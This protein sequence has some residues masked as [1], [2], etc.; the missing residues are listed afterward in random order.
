M[1]INLKYSDN[2]DRDYKKLSKGRK[3]YI[4]KMAGKQKLTISNYLNLKYGE[5]ENETE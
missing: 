1:S 2:L 3:N 5:I 4:K